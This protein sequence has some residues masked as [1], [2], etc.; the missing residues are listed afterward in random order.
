MV[1]RTRA[2]MT[3]KRMFAEVFVYL[4]GWVYEF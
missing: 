2:V 3:V 1:A 4:L